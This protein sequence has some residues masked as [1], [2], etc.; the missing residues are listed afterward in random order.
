MS[1]HD[2]PPQD[3]LVKR[4]HDVLGELQSGLIGADR[5][6]TMRLVLLAALAGEH[7]LLIGPPGTGKSLVAQRLHRAFD[8]DVAY[9]E[10]LLT[11]FTVPEELFG[12]LSLK[13]LDQEDKYERK[14]EG[15]LPHAS[16]A[17]LD[18]IFNANSAILNALLTILNERRFDNGSSRIDAKL[19]ALIA[20]S[21]TVPRGDELNAL[22]DRFLLRVHVEPLSKQEDFKELVGRP[23]TEP[24]SPSPRITKE[25][26]GE[27]KRRA[28]EV[29]VPDSVLDLLCHLREWCYEVKQLPVSDRRW[30]KIVKLLKV[31]A[32]MRGA[33]SVEPKDFHLLPLCIGSTPE[34]QEEVQKEISKTSHDEAYKS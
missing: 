33:E 30:T 24:V 21:N 17:F 1:N 29:T 11:R 13:K 4:I 22:F 15:Y 19:V 6:D 12:P 3:E 34:V 2:R 5:K 23:S 10:R 16:I 26:L 25:V 8:G 9:F 20:A 14:I 7:L 18:E 32:V 31:S 27:V 28:T